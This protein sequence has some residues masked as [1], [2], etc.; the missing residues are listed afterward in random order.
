[1]AHIFFSGGTGVFENKEDYE[2]VKASFDQLRTYQEKLQFWQELP[3]L[4]EKYPSYGYY[5]T[6][7]TYEENF[8][9]QT[10]GVYDYNEQITILPETKEQDY[11]YLHWLIQLPDNKLEEMISNWDSF[12]VKPIAQR[13]EA[14][15]FLRFYNYKENEFFKS[16]YNAISE[17]K[18]EEFIVAYLFDPKRKHLSTAASQIKDAISWHDYNSH[19]GNSNI[20]KPEQPEEE[21]TQTELLFTSLTWEGDKTELILLVKSLKEAGLIKGDQKQIFK[22]FSQLLNIN[23]TDASNFL[24][25]NINRTNNDYVPKIFDK[26]KEAYLKYR[27]KQLDKRDNI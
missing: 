10:Y 20:H 21:S 26:L 24:S 27:D 16:G 3:F 2:P 11:Y 9:K 15:R 25:K 23:L 8:K 13:T 17:G 19:I 18:L 22:A 6:I 14:E 5:A 1:M 7:L 4:K 12:P